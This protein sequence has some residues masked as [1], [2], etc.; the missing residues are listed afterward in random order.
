MRPRCPVELPGHVVWDTEPTWDPLIDVLGL[1]LVETFMWMHQQTVPGGEVAHAYKHCET[2]RYLYLTAG[3]RA[4]QRTPCGR[5]VP[6]RVDHAIEAALAYWWVLG[7]M[8]DAE[9]AAIRAAMHRD[10][11]EPAGAWPGA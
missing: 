8:S 7:T 9:A 1:E 2:R 4:F 5:L 11:P 6:V 10:W 3:L